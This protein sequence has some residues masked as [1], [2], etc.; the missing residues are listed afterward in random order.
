MLCP[1]IC[2]WTAL[3]WFEQIFIKIFVYILEVYVE[4]SRLFF[5]LLGGKD[6]RIQMIILFLM[7]SLTH[8]TRF[9]RL[10]LIVDAVEFG[11]SFSNGS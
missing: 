9:Q 5:I 10:L 8:S 4:G 6:V 11:T 2:N 3:K 1:N 7:I